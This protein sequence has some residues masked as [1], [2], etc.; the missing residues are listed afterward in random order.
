MLSS[1][2]SRADIALAPAWLLLVGHTC[3]AHAAADPDA[4]A[5]EVGRVW[6]VVWNFLE[7]GEAATRQAAAQSL[8]LLTKCFTLSLV[9]AAVAEAPSILSGTEPKSA[10]GRIVVQ[11]SKAL[12]ALA[13]ARA[14]PELLAVIASLIEQLHVRPDGPD[15]K[16]AAELLLL[17]LVEKIAT[18][19][20]QKSFEYKEDADTVLS[21]AMKVLGPEVLLERLPLNLEPSDR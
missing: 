7:S 12:D 19:R 4:S 18:L 9:S 15:G 3:G 1:L 11:V 17:P 13:T 2:P 14:V 6:K 16:T 5:K 20:I 21:T 8:A 10:V